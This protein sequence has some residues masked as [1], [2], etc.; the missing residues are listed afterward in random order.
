MIDWNEG[1]LG[2]TIIMTT[3]G[4]IIMLAL[5]GISYMM[6]QLLKRKDLI[7]FTKVELH[8]VFMSV[9]LLLF[10][11]IFTQ[12][13]L[14][15]IIPYMFGGSPYMIAENYI[16]NL[17]YYELYPLVRE[18]MLLQAFIQALSQTS[19]TIQIVEF[20]PFNLSIIDKAISWT[21]LLFTPF[22][23]SLIVQQIGLQIIKASM[24]SMVLPVGLFLRIFPMTRQAGTF[25]IAVAVGF[26]LVFPT[27]YIIHAETVD[28]IHLND[29][30]IDD[31]LNNS[32]IFEGNEGQNVKDKIFD[33]L[34]KIETY[35]DTF[36]LPELGLASILLGI[37]SFIEG[38]L[39]LP[40]RL[41]RLIFQGTFLPTLSI[42]LTTSFII[43]FQQFV[44][45]RFG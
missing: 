30:N 11:I 24:Y 14:N 38:I 35:R 26:Y 1:I 45:Q 32:E 31:V 36:I 9:L 20:K 41:G 6:G 39:S 43:S 29:N 2:T 27:T 4:L 37:H 34:Y 19:I 18:M 8:Q 25:M 16:N 21:L 10:I 17:I 44:T 3:I 15:I 7:A 40:W 22:F 13:F 5:I 28:K 33:V 12:V 42:I 23:S